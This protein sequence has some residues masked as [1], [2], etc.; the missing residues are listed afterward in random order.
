MKFKL[1]KLFL[2]FFF[3]Q[4]FIYAQSTFFIKY[5]KEVDKI[6]IDE[7]I[8]TQSILPQSSF[9]N[10]NK[11]LNIKTDVSHLAKNL[12]RDDENL[13]RIIKIDLNVSMSVE[14]FSQLFKDD[15]S[16]E[17]IERSHT[18]NV[19]YTPNDSLINE[20]WAL[21]KIKAFAAWN[22]TQ[23]S[24]SI[25][26]GV[27]DTGID[28]LHPDLK[29]N[30]WHN[31]GEIGID[32][33]GK[34]K[35]S[36]GIDDD[37][38]GFIDDWQGWDFVD[39]V[40]FP[41]DTV[42]G[43]FLSWDNNP[44]D[45]VPGNLG[46]HGTAVAG[47]IGSENNN[48][49]GISGVAPKVKILNLRSFDNS[50][51]GEEDDAAAA[52]LYA[53]NAG[54]KVINMSFGDYT[55]SYVLRDVIRYAYSKNVVLVASSGNTNDSELH[56]PSG[57]PEVISVGNSTKDDFVTGSYGSTLDLTAPGTDII[58][59]TLN[60]KYDFVS[61]TS[62]SAPHVA[63]AAGLV[64]SLANFTNEEVKQIL[65]STS[66]DIGE[67]GWDEKNGAGRLN[68][69]KALSVLAPAKVKINYPSQDFST[70]HD[71]LIINL[72]VISPY[73]LNF[74]LM[75]GEGLNPNTWTSLILNH[76]TQIINEDF[77]NLNLKDFSEGAYTIRVLMKMNNGNTSEERINFYVER[78]APLVELAGV[79]PVYYGDKS[80]I[81]G[82]IYT[83]QKT[84]AR[85]YYRKLGEANFNFITLDGFNTNNQ[86]VKQ[87]HY[88]IIPKQ[89]IQPNTNYEIYFEAE[90]LAGLKTVLK[91]N[92]N[93]FN[94]KTDDS[95]SSIPY[96]ELPFSLPNG[97]VFENPVNFLSHNS[98]EVLF[99]SAE[100]DDTSKVNYTLY[101]FENDSLKKYD[102]F[103]NKIPI[104]SFDFNKNG[105]E[106]LLSILYPE[107]F[108]DE[109]VQPGSFNFTNKLS[110]QLSK[111]T[112]FYPVLA[113]DL[114]NDNSTEILSNYFS[115]QT[116]VWKINNDLSV[117]K[118]DSL[119]NYSFISLFDQYTSGDSANTVA[120]NSFAIADLNGDGIKEIWM[121][122]FDGDLISYKILNSPLH[123]ERGDSLIS[124]LF[125]T[126]AHK[127][128]SAGDFDGDGID[129]LAVLFETNNIAPNFWLKI[130]NFKNGQ[131]NI[132]YDKLFLDQS[133]EFLG[134]GFTKV[135]QSL[136][137][138]D[139]DND[140]KDEL[141]LNIF[142]CFYIIKNNSGEGEIVFYKDGINTENIFAGDINNNNVNEIGLQSAQGFRFYEFS[143][144]N[145]AFTPSNLFGYS[146]DSTR[147]KIQWSGA[148]QKYYIYRGETEQ[149][150]SL[151]DSTAQLFY[152]DNKVVNKKIYFYQIQA[153]DQNK[154]NN[155]S[156]LT[157][158]IK[159]YSHQPANITK[160]K[161]D[162]PSTLLISFS[163]LINNTI[164]NLL[165]FE[166]VNFGFPNSISA[167]SQNSYLLT[168]KND[169]PVG[170]NKLIIKN[171]NDYYGSPIYTDTLLFNVDP[172][173]VK[174]EFYISSHEIINPFEIKIS[175]NLDVDESSAKNFNN[176][177][178][179]PFNNISKI[180]V[181]PTDKKTIYVYLDKTKPIGAIG[182][183]YRLHILNLISSSE[184]GSLQINSGAGSY[185]VLTDF[186]D[187]LSEI[188]VYPNPFKINGDEKKITFANL[189]KKA[190]IVIFKLTGEKVNE[191]E[192]NNG[193]GGTEFNLKDLHGNEISS[194]VY[195]YRIVRLDNSN[196]EVE[197]KLGKF[198]VVK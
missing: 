31:K 53:V 61:G 157:F 73:F 72:T 105:K 117:S 97:T 58:S 134:F 15:N 140:G 11:P 82:E 103:P 24:D 142:P 54:A 112:S 174:E 33:N 106:D 18:Y 141:T 80:T 133:A 84:I 28:Y 147:I 131:P 4:N 108:I 129:E 149:T 152:I 71:S 100:G 184:T 123:F 77:F 83:D 7:K 195:I 75:V 118:F 111:D 177:E 126:G 190:K 137:F 107:S 167:A 34:D 124:Q 9:Q 55:F 64:L 165:S 91:D 171:I 43:D 151:Y 49:I 85:L 173:I 27:I 104:Y 148:G 125:I 6:L 17:Y 170:E 197:Q 166:V 114:D 102:T 178:F 50:G 10:L 26:I 25:I 161:N 115:R 196:N 158:S 21:E 191:L 23:G 154:Q 119:P 45:K 13:S 144:S 81:V 181:D 194:G 42:G 39:R 183:E 159:I 130:L 74:S 20:Q 169:L 79:G 116:T 41:F 94:F 175:Y 63:G 35:S 3:L 101:Y 30:I 110:T 162:S 187:N 127:I 16:I 14:E 70:F 185:I 67:I 62:F 128:I 160:I 155:F 59:T 48:T 132:L 172:A 139:L 52:I 1:L 56:Y 44:F 66:D 163:D 98:N 156:D 186:A 29:N 19:D 121:A 193:D 113:M 95:P 153:F 36:N 51:N 135:F 65:K 89:I 143:E 164:E 122:D 87:Y 90:N 88:G 192:E 92:K 168:F 22:I 38:N 86:F 188:Y 138:V 96:K 179:N 146:L 5:K 40:G 136:R 150:I 78:S 47:V 68:L 189:P 198:A 120:R 37:D 93:Y 2:F 69:F 180:E 182:R 145:K 12:G 60:N 8:K 76:K 57:Y 32:Q 176:Y 99:N 46:F 109:Q